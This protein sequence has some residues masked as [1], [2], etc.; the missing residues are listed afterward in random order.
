MVYGIC[1]GEPDIT[2]AQHPCSRLAM[3]PL[4]RLADRLHRQPNSVPELGEQSSFEQLGDRVTPGHT[5]VGMHCQAGSV[6]DSGALRIR[7]W[8]HLGQPDTDWWQLFFDA[9]LCVEPSVL[10]VGGNP[11]Q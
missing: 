1:H 4:L 7:S 10:G 6:G 3:V 2:V 8:Q 5:V 9:S 11:G